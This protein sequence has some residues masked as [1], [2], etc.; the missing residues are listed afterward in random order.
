MR[1]VLATLLIGL[2]APAGVIYTYDS[3]GRL[4]KVDYGN[5]ATITYT[6]DKVGNLLIRTVQSGGS[7]SA[8]S[9]GQGRG[10]KPETPE[11]TKQ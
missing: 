4:A 3:A 11:Q 10:A 5:G 9:S 1:I 7:T 6:Y 2:A 8:S